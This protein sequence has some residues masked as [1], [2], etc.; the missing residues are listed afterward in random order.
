[1]AR[2]PTLEG[3]GG[4]S[5]LKDTAFPHNGQCH[6]TKGR[7]YSDVKDERPRET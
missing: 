5:A 7:R 6:L 2:G 1:M 4:R 3:E